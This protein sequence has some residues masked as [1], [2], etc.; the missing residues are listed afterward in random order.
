MFPN[1]PRIDTSQD[2]KTTQS[3]A[4]NANEFYLSVH[5]K[6]TK[7]LI[8]KKFY[9]NELQEFGYLRSVLSFLT[10]FSEVFIAITS[11]TSC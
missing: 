10:H 2:R 6:F 4:T 3:Q 8:T 9:E 5:T 11:K 1:S 7:N